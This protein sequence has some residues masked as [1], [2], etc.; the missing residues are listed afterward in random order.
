MGKG[1]F[2]LSNSNMLNETKHHHIHRIDER[3]NLLVRRRV[4][5]TEVKQRMGLGS[6]RFNGDNEWAKSIIYFDIT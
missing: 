2:P 3:L 1:K 6:C 4:T 5:K